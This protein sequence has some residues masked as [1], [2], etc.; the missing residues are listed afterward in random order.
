MTQSARLIVSFSP[1]PVYR[2]HHS[3]T[4]WYFDVYL[5]ELNGVGATLQHLKTLWITEQGHVQDQMEES[6][7]I[8]I[9]PREQALFRELWV[10]SALPRFTYRVCLTGF[11][12][13]G[14]PVRV[15]GDLACW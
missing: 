7:N 9:G 5:Q 2:N 13:T 12:E 6:V 3:N 8:V 15:E 10:S 11:D 14:H 4:K 1:N